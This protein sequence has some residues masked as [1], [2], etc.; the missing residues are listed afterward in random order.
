MRLDTGRRDTYSQRLS[1]IVPL[2]R[3]SALEFRARLLETARLQRQPQAQHQQ[4]WLVVGVELPAPNGPATPALQRS[5]RRCS[6]PQQ[7]CLPMARQA[8]A[9]RATSR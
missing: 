4:R 3:L 7:A 2:Q 9:W 5:L 1:A 6:T 8:T